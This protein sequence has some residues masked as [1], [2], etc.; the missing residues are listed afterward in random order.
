MYVTAAIDGNTDFETVIKSNDR[1]IYASI[2]PKR[3]AGRQELY[4]KRPAAF[5]VP[6]ALR[7]RVNFWKKIYSE[8][9]T[10]HYVVHDLEN[11]DVIYEVVYIKNGTKMSRKAKDRRLER[12]KRKYKKLLLKIS[13]T[14]KKQS[15]KMD[16]LLA[17]RLIM[18]VLH[19]A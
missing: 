8:Y 1:T 14:K 16:F 6:R 12:V 11:L 18:I 17:V 4:F 3:S 10:E 5:N 7:P 19:G 13:R 15:L 2:A 9:S